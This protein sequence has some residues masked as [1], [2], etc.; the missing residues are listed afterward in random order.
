MNIKQN[1]ETRTPKD[2]GVVTKQVC[3]ECKKGRVHCRTVESGCGGYED[4]KL[5]CN[6]CN[7]SYWIDG[8]DS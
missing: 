7:Y 3:K 2:I 8:I 6:N 1:K 5:T 4:F